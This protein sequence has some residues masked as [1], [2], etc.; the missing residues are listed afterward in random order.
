LSLHDALPISAF[1]VISRAPFAKIAPFKQRM[2]WTFPWLSSHGT[3]FN[4]DFGV[5]LDP[6]H[7]TY[8]YA[9]VTAQPEGR[10]REGEREGLSVFFR[11]GTRVS[12]PTLPTSAV[13]IHSSTQIGRA[14]V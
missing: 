12:T 5:T 14:H 10:P 9:P 1:A 11:D 2:G 3:D 4:G 7:T 6:T 8:N 13:S